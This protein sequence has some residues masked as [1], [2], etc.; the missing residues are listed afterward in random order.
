M[1]TWT[2][3]WV[4]T[5]IA[6]AA[7][8]AAAETSAPSLAEVLQ[9][10]KQNS[11]GVQT[12][13]AT[14]DVARAS[15]SVA[16]GALWP[17]LSASAGFTRNQYDVVVSIP[18][19]AEA[20]IEATIQ[21]FNQL[22]ATVQI[23]VPL[24][25]IASRRQ[26]AFAQQQRRTS[27]S[28]LPTVERAAQREAIAAYYGWLAGEALRTAAQNSLKTA[29]ETL[30]VTQQR[31]TAGL[32]VELDVAK[33]RAVVARS[34]RQVSDAALTSSNASRRLQTLTGLT[35]AAT[36]PALSADD[37]S[38]D[39]IKLDTLLA[40]S[41]KLPEIHFAQQQRASEDAALAVRKAAYFPKLDAFA[42]ERLTNAAGFG[43]ASAWAVGVAAT[44]HFDR[45]ATANVDVARAS[46]NAA[47]VRQDVALREAQDR[48]IDAQ[49]QV[50]AYRSAV[51]AAVAD[52][53]SKTLTATVTERR[54]SQGVATTL[55]VLD[56]ESEQLDAT[57]ELIRS[58]A[59]LAAARALL[60]LEAG[61]EQ[62]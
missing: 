39:D 47:K 27:E 30:V 21:P 20:P 4:T 61:L 57:V 15:Q 43:N 9:A 44:W 55:Q 10:A 36:P 5:V 60:R 18:R 2:S 33:A 62:P 1:K 35:F 16:S 26:S 19:G 56:A 53:E 28:S 59:N 22:E 46:A 45:V 58:R 7:S 8:P 13:R 48:I 37:K 14:I 11:L 3:L 17:R 41:D 49:Q 29:N 34:A 31:A 54:A 51:A 52:L 38:S 40:A 50:I 23:D 12:Q 32:S 6:M 42:R 25:D 24:I